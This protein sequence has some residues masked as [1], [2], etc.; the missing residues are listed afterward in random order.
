MM[1]NLMNK[2][3]KLTFIYITLPN[4]IKLHRVKALRDFNDVNKGDIGGY[5]Q[6]EANLSH[7][8]KCWIYNDAKVFGDA[9]VYG[10]AMIYNNA[11]VYDN[12]EI[13]GNAEISGTVEIFKEARVSGNAQVFGNA[14]VYG[15]SIVYDNSEI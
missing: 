1:I 13:Y 15:K 4:G 6:S 12:V 9:E 14:K 5:V 7:K 8:G 11:E 10:N 2:K 3:Y